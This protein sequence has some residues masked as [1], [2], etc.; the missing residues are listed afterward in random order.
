MRS[1]LADLWADERGATAIEY[2]L[3]AA[4]MV[5]VVVAGMQAVGVALKENFYD[6]IANIF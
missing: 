6:K 5:V 1:A 2:G 4:L 3:I